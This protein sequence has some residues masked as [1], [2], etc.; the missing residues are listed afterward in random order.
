MARVYSEVLASFDYSTVTT[1][2]EINQFNHV[3]PSDGN[4][5]VLREWHVSAVFGP[6]DP[7]NYAA[8][9]LTDGVPGVL[10]GDGILLDLYDPAATPTKLGLRYDG[11][12]V[13]PSTWVLMLVLNFGIASYCSGK[14]VATGYRLGP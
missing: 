3:V 6:S 1:G 7:E 2:P 11:R 4:T 12:I 5:Y 10:P 8:L 9:Y 14:F 13:L